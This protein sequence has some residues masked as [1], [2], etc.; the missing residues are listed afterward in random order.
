MLN[1]PILG[2]F[3]FLAYSV[4]ERRQM[5]VSGGPLKGLRVV[6]FVGV[7]PGPFAAMWLADMGAEVIRVDRPGQRWNQTRG[8]IL[9]RGR[10]SMAL[11]L[12]QA[13]AAEVALRLL[14][15]ADILLEG[16]RPGV[17]ERLGLGPDVCMKRNP[18]LVYGRVTGWGQDGPRAG[19][20]GH[21]INYI[22]TTGILATIGAREGRPM[23][24][25]NLLGDFGGGGLLLVS[26]VLAALVERSVSGRGQIVDAAMCEG[27][28]LLAGMIWSYHNKGLWADEREANIFDGGAPYYRCYRCRDNR[29]VAVGA[30]EKSFWGILL[31]CCGIEDDMLRNRRD[32]RSLWPELC[33]RMEAI[34]ET[35]DCAHWCALTEG[36]DACLTPVLHFDEIGRDGHACERSSFLERDAALQPSPAPRFSRSS[37]SVTLPSPLVGEHTHEILLEWGFS[38]EEIETLAE[39][40]L[41]AQGDGD[42]EGAVASFLSPEGGAAR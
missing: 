24:P 7:G 5:A 3:H 2:L 38:E 41:I 19:Q 29:F 27:A 40:R 34:F 14:D 9:N 6:E 36:T 10:R 39:G 31:D 28:S 4:V 25:L 12:K 1:R 35:E 11:D 42:E 15:R 21:D 22:A 33:A 23:P 26:G 18:R 30:I 17:M 8:D 37:P 32:E 16:F 13:G 20:A